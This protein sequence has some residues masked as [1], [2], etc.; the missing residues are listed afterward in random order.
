MGGTRSRSEDEKRSASGGV[1][2]AQ[3]SD[4]PGDGGP[5]GS[6]PADTSDQDSSVDTSAIRSMLKRRVKQNMERP[7]SSLGSVKIEEFAGER[8]RMMFGYKH[9]FRVSWGLGQ[10]VRGLGVRG[11][12]RDHEHR[13]DHH[14]YWVQAHL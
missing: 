1:S 10:G 11:G 2:Q 13:V 6:S 8:S 12:A 5:P 9:T 14:V 7:K 3:R 4:D